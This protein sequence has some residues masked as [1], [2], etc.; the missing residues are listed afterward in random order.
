MQL[1]RSPFYK[2]IELS[3]YRKIIIYGRD[4]VAQN[5]M[6][7]LKL[8]DVE[9]DYFVDENES[10]LEL[11]NKTVKNYY[12]LLY[13]HPNQFIVLYY[14]EEA[15]S[16]LRGIGLKPPLNMRHIELVS[17]TIE[18]NFVLDANLGYGKKGNCTLPGFVQ[19]GDET[20]QNCI[21]LLGG[22]TADADFTVFPCLADCLQ[23][24]LKK[25]GY[26][27]KILCG[28][29][30]GY[31][32]SQELVKLIRDAIPMKPNIVICYNGFND[33][34]NYFRKPMHPFVHPYQKELMENLG[35]NRNIYIY[36]TEGYVLGVDSQYSAYQSWKNSVRMMHAICDE[37]GIKYRCFLQ[38]CL[39]TKRNNMG[40]K[41]WEIWLH[42]EL[43]DEY[44]K[45]FETFYSEKKIDD[46]N[47]KYL[48]DFSNAFEGI[49]GAY[50]DN[51][52]VWE[53]GNRL[54]AQ[55]ICKKIMDENE[56][57]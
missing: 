30:S 53:G 15:Y 38:P 34:E 10:A 12:E 25:N 17:E 28:A 40:K 8:L 51:C 14:T 39:Y 56:I 32:S 24:E 55:K 11:Y 5:L 19:F 6:H 49:D 22:S 43:R 2:I 33:I 50:Y 52:H 36:P 44:L 37:Y 42:Y 27:T 4:K 46:W 31:Q 47:V 3:Y 35:G 7:K 21:V 16:N 41:D 20:V 29:I 26:S 18:Q 13:E 23:Q 45:Q 57:L 54:I 9:V 48:S 1:L